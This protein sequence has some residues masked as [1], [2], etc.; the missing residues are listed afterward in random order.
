MSGRK[1][2]FGALI[3]SCFT[4]SVAHFSYTK[5][6][7][8]RNKPALSSENTLTLRYKRLDRA[9]LSQVRA[10]KNE[11][12]RTTLTNSELSH[13]NLESAL[14]SGSLVLNSK[15][16]H[17]KLTKS[18]ID[19]LIILNTSLRHADLSNAKVNELVVFGSDLRGADLRGADLKA[20]RFYLSRFEGARCD[21]Q[22]QLPFSQEEANRRGLKC[23]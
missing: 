4:L 6:K 14:V 15:A 8:Q 18:R 21:S 3:L 13:M 20:A 1:I 17:I 10:H 5:R 22:T 2:Y 19:N 16:D 12:Y 23:E 11:V 7:P 9:D